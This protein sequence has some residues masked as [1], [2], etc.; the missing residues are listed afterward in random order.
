MS[1]NNAMILNKFI[2]V[3]VTSAI[4]LKPIYTWGTVQLHFAPSVCVL[5]NC[6]LSKMSATRISTSTQIQ[7]RSKKKKSTQTSL[8]ETMSKP[9]MKLIQ[10]YLHGFIRM[11]FLFALLQLKLLC[12]DWLC[13]FLAVL[14]RH[15]CLHYNPHMGMQS[16]HSLVP[17]ASRDRKTAM[18]AM[19]LLSL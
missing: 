13:L 4:S 15:A 5:D 8:S 10:L 7:W 12:A 9:H 11:C 2:I 1:N 18:W 14:Q 19:H 17:P 3:I 6:I 16:Q